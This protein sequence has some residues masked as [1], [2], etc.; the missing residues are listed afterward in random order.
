MGHGGLALSTSLASMLNLGLLVW[1]LRTKLGVLGLKSIT[2]S[3]CK[4]MICSGVM[5]VVVWATGV[6]IIPPEDGTSSG[7][8]FGLMGSIVTGLI[9]YGSFSL[10]L[11]S[12]ELKNV[13]AFAGK[14]KDKK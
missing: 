11:K 7:L 3:A 10:L 6:L 12:T 2:E 1:A 13:L 14:G 8:F 9:L 4:T 5:G